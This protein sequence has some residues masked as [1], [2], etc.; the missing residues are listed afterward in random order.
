MKSRLVVLTLLFAAPAGIG[1]L[2]TG[3]LPRSDGEIK[4]TGLRHE[5]K[6]TFDPW[7]SLP[8]MPQRERTRFLPWAS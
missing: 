6:V 8:C 2:L 1:L 5:V 4:L 7:V 3:S